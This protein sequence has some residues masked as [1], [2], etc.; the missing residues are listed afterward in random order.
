MGC[1]QSDVRTNTEATV[2]PRGLGNG[3]RGRFAIG[4]LPKLA[5]VMF[6]SY[7]WNIT[8]STCTRS[9]LL[10]PCAAQKPNQAW[11]VIVEPGDAPFGTVITT[12]CPVGPATVIC[13]PSAQSE[14]NVTCIIVAP[15][16]IASG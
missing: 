5:T 9:S 6:H 14:G 8:Q 7:E 11:T 13:C 3:L 12:F 4:I 16:A 15:R 10:T 1:V 2:R